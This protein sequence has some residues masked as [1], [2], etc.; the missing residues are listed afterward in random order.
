MKLLITGTISHQKNDVLE[1]ISSYKYKDDVV[2]LP[3]LN[4]E[5]QSDIIAAAYCCI[6]PSYYEGISNTVL[7]SMQSGVPIIASDI[8][9]MKEVC[10]E[11]C[12]Y[13]SPDDVEDISNQMKLLYR[14]E[15]ERNLLIAKGLQQAKK[16]S[17]NVSSEIF[18]MAI[19]LASH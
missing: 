13:I 5:Q 12:S 9:G 6:L 17:W 3:S 10:G 15:Q 8:A 14:D 18:W 11:A 1:K 16:F 7:T 4:K 19:L 2:I